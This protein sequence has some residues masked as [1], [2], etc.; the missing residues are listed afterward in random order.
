[1]FFSRGACLLEG[2]CLTGRLCLAPRHPPFALGLLAGMRNPRGVGGGAADPGRDAPSG[3]QVRNRTPT[4]GITQ[5]PKK[6]P[7][8]PGRF[9]FFGCGSQ[10]FVACLL[11]CC[12]AG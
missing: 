10:P 3:T 5:P 7:L 8:S 12:L 6:K 4:A 11:A 1:M 9:F 2:G